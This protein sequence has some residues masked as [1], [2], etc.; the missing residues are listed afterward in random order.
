MHVYLPSG[1]TGQRP[2]L[3]IY[4]AVLNRRACGRLLSGWC[5]RLYHAYGY[6]NSIE[7][8]QTVFYR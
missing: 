5:G 6:Y 7:P 4:M 8:L 2:M 1:H 3:P